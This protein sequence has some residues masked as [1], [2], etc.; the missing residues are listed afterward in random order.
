[1]ASTEGG[2]QSATVC[3]SPSRSGRWEAS[4]AKHNY[5]GFKP[6]T[7]CLRCSGRRVK[8]HT[9]RRACLQASE[10]EVKTSKQLELLHTKATRAKWLTSTTVMYSTVTCCWISIHQNLHAACNVARGRIFFFKNYSYSS[11]TEC[12]LPSNP[13]VKFQFMFL[14]STKIWFWPWD[15]P[16]PLD[17]LSCVQLSPIPFFFWMGGGRLYTGYRFLKLL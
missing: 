11:H 12:T 16:F 6:A 13:S 1:M 15:S 5:E 10:R 8:N 2:L 17:P 3:H 9:F 4:L 14:L 7:C